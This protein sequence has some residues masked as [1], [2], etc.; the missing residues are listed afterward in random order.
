MDDKTPLR[1][2]RLLVTPPGKTASPL[3][4]IE[5][6]TEASAWLLADRLLQNKCAEKPIDRDSRV[7]LVD[8]E[9]RRLEPSST[10]GKHLE[11]AATAQE[12]TS[13]R[14]AE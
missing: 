11:E 7:E 3:G 14:Q 12:P 13:T 1:H 2:F 5:A 8:P 10:V 6:D 4:L 9:G